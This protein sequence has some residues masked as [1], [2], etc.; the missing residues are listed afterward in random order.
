MEDT[1]GREASSNRKLRF[2]YRVK[3]GKMVGEKKVCQQNNEDDVIRTDDDVAR[4][5]RCAFIPTLT[6]GQCS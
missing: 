6:R 3:N 1:G 2:Y 4:K 5:S